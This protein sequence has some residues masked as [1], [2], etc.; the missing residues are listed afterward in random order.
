MSTETESLA[1]KPYVRLG[2]TIH[3]RATAPKPTRDGQP[4]LLWL[5]PTDED[6]PMSISLRVQLVA[7]GVLVYEACFEGHLGDLCRNFD[8]ILMRIPTHDFRRIQELIAQIRTVNTAPIMLI[9]NN[10]AV[11]WSIAVLPVGADAV[12]SIHT[13]EAIILAR[14]MALLR[15]WP[16]PR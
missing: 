2:C 6:M 8:L 10:Y 9:T 3:Q 1:R 7:Q 16:P 15:R 5:Q 4:R 14:C 12:E 13:P 11:P